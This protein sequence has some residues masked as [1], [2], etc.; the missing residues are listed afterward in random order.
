MYNVNSL[1]LP[2]GGYDI[3]KSL[4][5]NGDTDSAHLTRTPSSAS[6]RTTF[7]WSAWIKTTRVD[8]HETL[9]SATPSGDGTLQYDIILADGQLETYGLNSGFVWDKKLSR[10]FRDPSAWYHLVVAFDTTD[11]TAEDRIKIYVNGERQTDFATNSNPSINTTTGFNNTTEHSIGGR[12]GYSGGQYFEGYQTEINFIDGLQLGPESFGETDPVTGAWVP[13]SYSGS[14][15]TNG[16]YLNFLDNSNNTATTLGKDSSGN[17]NN[18]TPNNFSVS[19]GAGNDS[20]E[21]T[22]TNNWC[23]L[24]SVLGDSLNLTSDGNLRIGGTN[25]NYA[26]GTI[27][28][29]SSGKYYAEATLTTYS[30]GQVQIGICPTGAESNLGGDATA[31]LQDGSTTVNNSSSTSLT[32]YTQ[33]DVIGIAVDVDNSTVQFYKNNT[34]QTA[35]TSVLR[36]TEA[37]F[38]C[39]MSISSSVVNFNFGQRAFAYTPPTGFK[40]LNTKNLP[41]PIIADG[42][43][44]FNTV[45][46]TGNGSSQAVTGVGFQPDWV[47]TKGRGSATYNNHILTDSSRGVGNIIQSNS[48][49]AETA[50]ATSL[51]SFD[52]DGFSLGSFEDVN[53]N[54]NTY[55]AWNWKLNGGTSSTN[56]DGNITSTVQVNANA[57]FSVVLYTG[58][59]SAASVGHGLG[60]TPNMIWVKNRDAAEHWIIDSRLVTGNANGTLHFNTDAE[61]TGG[62]NQFGSHTS[63]TFVVKTAGNINTSGQDYIAYC[64]SNVEGYSKVGSYTGNAS[65]NGPFVYCGFKPAWVLVKNADDTGGRNWGIQ[66]T[67]RKSTNPCD[68]QLKADTTEVENSGLAGSTFQI[69]MLS[70]GFKVRNNTGIWN[71]NDDTIIFMAFAERPFKYANA[72]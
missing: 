69:D 36:I 8:S 44:H 20:L 7:T 34:A 14:Y 32:S 16:F 19:A 65:T 42:R 26:V 10:V 23:T 60:V 40:A 41:S 38:F 46:Y 5:F 2:S 37:S 13:K 67:T 68:K 47:W 52:S 71:E 21:D 25:N 3:S 54:N 58:T 53:T 43:K 22:P 9:F 56:T 33:G 27:A 57:G 4:R 31:Y 30:S 49:A 1:F 50:A 59:G 6:N 61:Y 29:P 66:D 62:T 72:R 51:T 70:N 15:G 35:L 18:W 12:T 39:Y 64:F 11:S 24:N 28:F 17:G 45:L 63:T 55:V 48:A